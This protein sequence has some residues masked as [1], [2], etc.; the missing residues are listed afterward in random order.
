MNRALRVLLLDDN[1]DYRLLIEREL[2]REFSALRLQQPIDATA[3]A[4]ALQDSE[5]DLVITDYRLFWTDG[6]TIVREVKKRYP[7]CPVLMFTATGNEEV[8]V[9]AM[10]AG[11]DD[12][13]LKSPK[14][15]PCLMTAVRSVLKIREQHRARKQAEETLRESE[16]SYRGLFDNMLEGIAYCRMLFVD[17][18]PQDNMRQ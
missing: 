17:G 7:D 2:K 18:R 15:F 16:Q 13:I 14:H 11:A 5:F 8:A 1:A 4:G 9:E 3:F 10:K 12:Y 6:V